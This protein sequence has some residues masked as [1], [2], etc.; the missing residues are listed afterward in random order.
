M[1]VCVCGGGGGGGGSGGGGVS[2]P[3][4]ALPG[5]LHHQSS[6]SITVSASQLPANDTESVGSCQGYRLYT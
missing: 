4:H 1:C 6:V 5:H 2:Q 3:I